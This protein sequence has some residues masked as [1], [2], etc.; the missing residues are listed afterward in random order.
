MPDL[1]LELFSEEIPARMQAR[2][3]EDLRK[4]VTDRAGRRRP[5]LR[6]RQ[7]LRHA[8]P[9]GARGAGRAGRAAR[10]ARGEEGPARR[11]AGAGASQGFLKAAGLKSI[12]E[13]KVQP[14]K[15]GDFYVAVIEK[16]GRPAIE[17]IAEIVPEVVQ[18]FPVAEVDAL[19]RASA[20]PVRSAGCG[21]CIPSS[22]PSG[23][24]P[25]S[26]RSF[27]FAVDGIAAGDDDPRPPLPGAGAVQGAPLRRLRGEAREGQGR[28]RSRRGARRSSSPTPSNLAFAQGFELVED[29]GLLGGGRR[30][31][32]MAGGAD[33]LVRRGVPRDPAG[34]DPHHH[35][36]QPEMLRARC[37]MPRT[38]AAK[39][40]PLANKFILVANIEADGR[41][42]GDRR[43][44][45][46]RDPRAARPTR[47][48]STRPT[49]RPGSKTGCR[50]SS[51]SSSTRS[52]ARSGE[53]IERI[54][55]LAAE[56]APHRRRRCREGQAR[57]A[58][59]QGR[60][61]HRGGRRVPRAA[62]PDG[63]VL[64]A[65]AGRG[66]ERRRAPARSTTSRSARPTA[67][68]PIRS[69]SRSRSPTRST[70]WSASGRSTRSRPDRRIRTRC[71]EQRW[72]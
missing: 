14:D 59:R 17:V 62:G 16:P 30:P 39:P 35:P 55:R 21:R 72:A 29:E 13:A 11:R 9:A 60:S 3:A 45:R 15:K 19:G 31:G 65:G 23:R 22:R 6:G 1:L 71:G 36:Q 2:A 33:G 63:Q 50:S 47:S 5:R 44:Q 40:P 42:Q 43:R 67:C 26:R 18:G 46:A 20:K 34:G 52:S 7:G 69:R 53:R 41:R 58:A 37:A 48:S 8:A 25:R 32:R 49:S 38:R 66:R 28:A 12:A 24:R 57:R 61:A 27:A 64:R 10:R 68:R 54:E 51:T 4:L 56:L 70:R